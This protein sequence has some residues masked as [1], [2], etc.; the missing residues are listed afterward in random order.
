MS[1]QQQPSATE[2]KKDLMA[3]FR[4]S[5]QLIMFGMSSKT[6]K[7]PIGYIPVDKLE[8]VL[9]EL[10]FGYLATIDFL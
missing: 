8:L 10:G 2:I 9:N 6:E 3:K 7:I 1:D 5:I 4:E